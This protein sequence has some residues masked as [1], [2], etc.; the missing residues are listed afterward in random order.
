MEGGDNS[1]DIFL[2]WQIVASLKALGEFDIEKLKDC[3][4]DVL[5]AN[6]SVKCVA[7]KLK[8]WWLNVK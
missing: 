8:L 1:I 3:E 7:Q 5:L 2:L 4:V 6:N